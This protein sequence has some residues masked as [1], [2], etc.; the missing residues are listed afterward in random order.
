MGEGRVG[1]GTTPSHSNRPCLE[2]E[3]Q[4]WSLFRELE[5]QPNNPVPR[6]TSVCVLGTERST[7]KAHVSEPSVLLGSAYPEVHTLSYA[8]DKCLHC[9]FVLMLLR[10]AFTVGVV[11]A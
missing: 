7:T 8:G 1:E 2:V 6:D 10:N 3:L 5:A 9:D 11:V 4:D